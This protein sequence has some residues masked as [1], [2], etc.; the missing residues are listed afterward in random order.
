[1]TSITERRA[2]IRLE[3]PLHLSGYEVLT[4][5]VSDVFG[6]YFSSIPPPMPE[7]CWAST[8][9]E[10]TAVEL[11]LEL[12]LEFIPHEPRR[13]IRVPEVIMPEYEMTSSITEVIMP[14]SESK[15]AE[16]DVLPAS[17]LRPGLVRRLGCG[18]SL[19][20]SLVSLNP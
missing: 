14:E 2:S 20:P 3:L 19:P 15:I 9:G 11:E 12:H 10:D 18:V 7:F 13:P 8:D 4:F 1:M 5:L 17:L 16:C 6:Y